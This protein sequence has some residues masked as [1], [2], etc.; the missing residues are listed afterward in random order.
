MRIRLCT[1]VYISDPASSRWCEL[2]ELGND[3][4]S[5]VTAC[6]ARMDASEPYFLAGTVPDGDLCAACRA[7]RGSP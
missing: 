2:V 7:L 1:T 6:G 4:A 3:R 5:H